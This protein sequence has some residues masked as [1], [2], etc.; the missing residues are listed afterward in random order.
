M[1][2]TV[3][4]ATSADLAGLS[5]I[6]LSGEPMFAQA[7]RVRLGPGLAERRW[8]CARSIAGR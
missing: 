1:A 3:R 7:A 5:A 2:L 8:Q 6:E 4:A